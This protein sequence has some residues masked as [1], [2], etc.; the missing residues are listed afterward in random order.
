MLKTSVS[1]HLV[2]R[3]ALLETDTVSTLDCTDEEIKGNYPNSEG[4]KVVGSRMPLT[5][6]LSL[7]ERRF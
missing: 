6:Q 5:A 1:P 2:L 4:Q 7:Q 3:K